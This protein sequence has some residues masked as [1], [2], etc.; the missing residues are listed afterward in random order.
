MT[1]I[2]G[3]QRVKA[4]PDKREQ[5]KHLWSQYKKHGSAKAKEELVLA[6]LHLVKYM[7]G[8]VAI[9]LPETVEQ[10]DLLSYGVFGLIDAVDKFDHTRGVK[11]ESYALVRIKGAILDGL[12]AADW[13]PRSVRQQARELSE[14]MMGLES[15]L[16]RPATDQEVQ[17]ALNL[18]STS[19]ANLLQN[20]AV[21]NLL[22]LDE[23]FGDSEDGDERLRL[24]DMISGDLD[25][26]AAIAEREAILDALS[27]AIGSLPERE[28]L[29]ITLYY[30]E[31]LTLREIG[32]VIGVTESRISQLHTKAL[33]RLRG[34]LERL[35][36]LVV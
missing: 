26:P 33:A 17:A 35:E 29:I 34:K 21:A 22:S 6:Y 3:E 23:P 30:Y 19:Y 14:V 20:I 36:I 9:S 24:I 16:G 1:E 15:Q 32:E 31:G 25:G 2:S 5:S 18:D 28:Q 4:M 10:D 27:K 11:F 13:A 12:R 8:R 7:A